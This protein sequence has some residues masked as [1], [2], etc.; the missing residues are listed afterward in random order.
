MSEANVDLQRVLPET[1]LSAAID[2]KS[3]SPV[4]RPARAP[5]PS[6]PVC[7]V[8]FVLGDLEELATVHVNQAIAEGVASPP[9]PGTIVSWPST[10]SGWA[11]WRRAATL[12]G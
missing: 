8:G 2:A 9:V 6:R 7:N 12:P 4:L 5:G 1:R 11:R 10:S 3:D